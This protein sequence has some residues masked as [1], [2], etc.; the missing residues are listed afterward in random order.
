MI[1]NDTELLAL[2]EQ[3]KNLQRDV[4]R[5]TTLH[6]DNLKM[7]LH[8]GSNTLRRREV[9]SMIVVTIAAVLVPLTIYY[10]HLSLLLC[11][12]S[13]A[14]LMLGLI[15]QIYYFYQ[16]HFNNLL[17]RPLIS[18]QISLQRYRRLNRR[19]LLFGGIPFSLIW[20]TW[21][22]YENV[23]ASMQM[24]VERSYA[25]R[26]GYVIGIVAAMAIGGVIG[27]LLGYF[28]FYRP[29]MRLAEEM[30]HNIAD[31]MSNNED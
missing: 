9:V 10:Q 26:A 29:Q 5:M 23:N 25:Y 31:L 6:V 27:G 18:A 22:A 20:F 21:Y 16:L 19:M 28:M 13:F 11:W 14:S 2:K 3:L 15:W 4:D 12:F 17:E 30:E 8:H 7:T 1:E 24:I